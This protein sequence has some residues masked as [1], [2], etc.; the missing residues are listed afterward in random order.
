MKLG[1]SIGYSG[2]RLDVP[3]KLV[4]RAEALG[5]DTVWTAAGLRLR[6]RQPPRLSGGRDASHPPRDRHHA[7]RRPHPRECRDVCRHGG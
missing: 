5:Y 3:V 1:L 6:C 4:Q 7:T 2:A